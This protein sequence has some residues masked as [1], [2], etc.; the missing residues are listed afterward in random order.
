MV[1]PVGPTQRV[2]ITYKYRHRDKRL[3]PAISSNT[4]DITDLLSG[5][6]KEIIIG[7]LM[8]VGGDLDDTD[9]GM[10]RIAD[11]WRSRCGLKLDVLME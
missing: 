1:G 4:L 8:T 9:S 3:H 5:F 7:G 2:T 10:V 6:Q 11:Q